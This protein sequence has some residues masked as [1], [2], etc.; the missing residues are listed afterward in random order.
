MLNQ[1]GFIVHKSSSH[2]YA[3]MY[4]RTCVCLCMYMCKYVCR[5]VCS[6]CICVCMYVN[7]YACISVTWP[8][9]HR[10]REKILPWALGTLRSSRVRKR[11]KVGL[12]QP[13]IYINPFLPTLT[14]IIFICPSSA[15]YPENIFLGRK[16]IG[17]HLPPC[18]PKLHLRMHVCLC[19]SICPSIPPS[20]HPSVSLIF[21]PFRDCYLSGVCVL[22]SV[23]NCLSLL[24]V[25]S[26]SDCHPFFSVS[27]LYVCSETY[28]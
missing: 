11:E 15:Q 5:Y 12:N 8:L 19:P 14:P 13:L 28:G 20:I 21:C 23:V 24:S 17:G 25:R 6:L 7:I 4:V 26:P 3:C 27:V 10:G 22:L 1:M 16:N 2:T 18:T 9:K